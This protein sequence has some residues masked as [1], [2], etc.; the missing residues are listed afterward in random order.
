MPGIVE[1]SFD[2]DVIIVAGA[3]GTMTI[4]RAGQLAW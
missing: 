4:M 3:A 1:H 2:G